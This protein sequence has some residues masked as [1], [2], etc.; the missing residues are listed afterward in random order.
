[1]KKSMY[2]IQ[3]EYQQIADA[4]TTGELTPELEH[5]LQIAEHELEV[6]SVNYSFVIKDINDEISIINAEIDRLKDLKKVRENALERLKNNISNAMQLFQVD[7]IKTPLIKINFRKSESVEV[8]NMALLDAKFLNEKITIT[9]DKMAIKEAIK[10]GEDVNGARL[11]INNNI[12][13]K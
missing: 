2:Q 13:I 6:K 1:M 11:V 3:S 7:E 8:D 10:N 12:Q 4:L 5:A 9:P